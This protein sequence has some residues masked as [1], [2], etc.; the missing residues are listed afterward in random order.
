M[1]LPS[2]DSLACFE[3]AARLL[4]FRAAARAVAL[5][6]AALGLRIKQL[7]DQL[8]VKL[9][10]RTTRRVQL[11]EAVLTLL[12]VARRCLG[13]A[14]ACVRAARGESGPPRTELT[15]GTR[16]ELGI[17]WLG[18][19]LAR[20]REAHPHVT[21][22]LYFGSGPDLLDRVRRLTLDAAVTSARL[23]D[24]GLEGLPL[25]D[26]RYVFVGAPALLDRVP[27]RR[28]EDA[29]HHTL[30]D[31]DADLPLFRYLREA[32]GFGEMPRFAAVWRLGAGAA[33]KQQALAGRGVAVL[34]RYLVE[35]ELQRKQ[36][37]RILP[38]LEPLSDRFRL[39]FR[40]DDPR[41]ALY[42]ALSATLRE[43]PLQ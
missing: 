29:R 3:A 35:G 38:R 13:E 41:R 1:P 36:L 4:H 23:Q 42:E 12:P 24:P 21:L 34:P 10:E 40:V 31:T 15:F 17:S 19:N 14:E 25:H 28:V 22:H 7:E 8:G 33:M 6:P 27:F 9:F 32:P 11:T 2:L 30:L 43:A 26:E 18:P 5:T 16:F 37:R 39:V 20:L